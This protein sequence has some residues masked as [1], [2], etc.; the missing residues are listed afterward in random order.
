MLMGA[1]GVEEDEVGGAP[2]TLCGI[3]FLW[4]MIGMRPP[5]IAGRV[6]RAGNILADVLGIVGDDDERLLVKSV[7]ALCPY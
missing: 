6:R 5:S 1:R 2:R 7:K 4:N 3:I